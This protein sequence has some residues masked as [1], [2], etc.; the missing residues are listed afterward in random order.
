MYCKD[1]KHWTRK[2]SPCGYGTCQKLHKTIDGVSVGSCIT[3]GFERAVTPAEFGCIYFEVKPN[4]FSAVSYGM[5]SEA[6]YAIRDRESGHEC[7]VA[8]TKGQ[9]ES[10]VSWLNAR[11]A[12]RCDCGTNM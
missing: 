5:P 3:T 12:E 2:R 1:C 6:R 9:A 11:W 7:F 8:L 4:K 10:L